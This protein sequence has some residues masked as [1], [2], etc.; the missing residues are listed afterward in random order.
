MVVFANLKRTEDIEESKDTL[1][2]SY[3]LESGVYPVKVVTAYTDFFKS[4]AQFINVKFE[5]AKPD[6]SAQNF[7][8]RLT[9]T[10]RQGSIFYLGKDGKKHALPGYETMDDLCLLTTG[11]TLAEQDTEKKVLKIWNPNEGKE[12]GTEVEC[13]TD[14]FGKSVLLAILKV[15]R[16]K[17]VADA[18][19]KYIDS[20]DEQLLNQTA[21]VFD[22]EY[23]TTVAEMRTAE[24][25]NV[26]PEA[27]F[28]NKWLER[29]ENKLRDEYKE[30][31]T[32]QAGFSGTTG[33]TSAQSRV[34]G[35][36]AS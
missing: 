22:S 1:G 3:I 7:N 29:N 32:S 5:V 28:I 35:R 23:R 34:F 27:T 19:G 26:A 25:N 20:K 12:V 14:L 10:N 18:S 31:I 16:N 15:R 4:G 24:R 11:K 21:K 2:G 33:S 9:I 17:Q 36:R 13:L 6:G 8:E 30:V